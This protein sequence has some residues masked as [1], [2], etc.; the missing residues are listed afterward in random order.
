VNSYRL[1]EHTADMGIKAEGETQA[2]LFQQMALG[3]RQIIT[4]CLDIR[5]QT[6]M[7]IEVVGMDRE[8][9]LVNWLNELVFLLETRHFLPAIFEIE[10]IDEQRLRALVRGE[11]FDPDRHFLER[12][13]KAI[14]YH[15]IKVESSGKGW[16]AQVFVDL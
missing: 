10:T 12:E 6:V 1:L 3:L 8:E 16:S 2:A 13:V 11:T 7:T 14:T 5:P 9:L 15:Q 4:E